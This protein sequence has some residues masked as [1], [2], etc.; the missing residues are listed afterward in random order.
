[1][2]AQVAQHRF[3]WENDN[4]HLNR[5]AVTDR[6]YTNGMR[7]SKL[8]CATSA[9]RW[10]RALVLTATPWAKG[11]ISEGSFTCGPG[12]E[13]RSSPFSTGWALG[14]SMYTPADI[15][16]NPPDPNDRPYGGW[17]YYGVMFRAANEPATVLQSW[18]IDLGIVGPASL[19]EQV[20]KGVHDL[21]G[22]TEPVGWQHQ[23]R[24]RVGLQGQYSV[25]FVALDDDRDCGN[26]CNRNF[27]LVPQVGVGI[28]S[29]FSYVSTGATLRAGWN[30]PKAW[31]ERI[32]PVRYSVT[33]LER[34]GLASLAPSY[35]YAFGGVDGRATAFNV[36]LDA[37]GSGVR[38]LPFIGDTDIG[39]V[40]GW[41]RL[42]LAYHLITRS[43]E[44]RGQPEHN[45]YGS[46]SIAW[47]CRGY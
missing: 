42:E 19:A 44:F 31:P 4:F 16:R 13:D 14:Q 40:I 24:S 3:V 5:S 11:V 18:E 6:A 46:I 37:A 1:M 45:Q 35:L 2:E 28:G 29:V 39:V 23:I 9:P 26:D 32:G 20:Q 22:A 41:P 21:L 38:K 12:E 33:A 15:S 30:I 8:R 34:S 25:R 27:D 47:N 17:L 43:P 7:Y 10:A 36:F